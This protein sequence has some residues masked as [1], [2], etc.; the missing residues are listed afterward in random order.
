MKIAICFYGLVGSV[1]DK[2]GVGRLLDPKIAYDYYKKNIFNKN[3]DVDIFIH[4][5]SV[6]TKQKLIDLY[7]PVDY[8]IENQ[9]LFPQS[10]KHPFLNK[11]IF[12]KLKM[13]FFKFFKNSLYIKLKDLKTKES[14]RAHSR[15][16][17]VNQSINLMRNHELKNNFS[18]D[19]VMSTRLDIG[20]FTPVS[21]KDYDMSYFYASNWNDAPIN[22]KNIQANYLN[23][24]IGKGFLDLWFFSNS[25][26]M[27]KFS[28]LF[29]KINDYPINPHTSSYNHLIKLTK[30][31]K[32]VFYRWHDHELIRRKFFESEK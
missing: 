1:S 5:Y 11:R 6:E 9:V 28:K 24:N 30:R 17:S 25:N 7:N 16:Y 10:E 12:E 8:T 26:L 14:F 13:A 20:F 21:F 29:D 23:Q 3:D 22:E 31:I 32:Y 2:N 15:W 4:S 27:F 19:C 18:Y